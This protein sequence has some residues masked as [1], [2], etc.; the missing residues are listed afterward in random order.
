MR[1]LSSSGTAFV[2][3]NAP[4]LTPDHVDYWKGNISPGRHCAFLRHVECL[5]IGISLILFAA[6]RFGSLDK[7]FH[8]ITYYITALASSLF[9]TFDIV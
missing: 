6:H 3:T 1:S 2:L 4:N 8:D 7:I 9:S 5:K